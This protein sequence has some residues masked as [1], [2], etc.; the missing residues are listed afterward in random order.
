[1]TTTTI[2]TVQHLSLDLVAPHPDNV[3]TLLGDLDDLVRSLKSSGIIV[4]LLVLPA[5]PDGVHHIVAGHRRYAAAVKAGLETVAVIVRDLTAVEVLDAMLIENGQ[6]DDL[7]LGDSILAMARY[8]VLAPSESATKIGKRIGRTAA[9]CKTRLALAVLPA[10]VLARLNDGELTL[11]VAT[12]VAGLVGEG[13]DA[14]RACAEELSGRHQHDPVDAVAR[15]LRRQE[16][17]RKLDALIE[18]LDATGVTRLGSRQDARD[19]KAMPLGADGLGLD[20]DQERAHRHEPCHAV[21]LD[22]QGWSGKVEK[23]NFCTDPKRHRTT[24]KN[25][26]VSEIAVETFAA[27]SPHAVNEE[28]RA[29]KAARVARVEAATILLSGNRALPK[30]DALAFVAHAVCQTAAS[31]AVKKACLML[32]IPTPNEGSDTWRASLHAWLEDGGHP[33]K[34]LVALSGGDLETRSNQTDPLPTYGD[35]AQVSQRWL[36]FLTGRAGYESQGHDLDTA[37][38]GV[39]R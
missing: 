4:P 7:S 30:G 26:A 39:T 21:L 28:G 22:A 23:I 29:R 1:M 15:W 17:Q 27:A 18:K 25:E 36:E 32:S 2:E 37:T 38:S 13:D 31:V 6:R 35:W 10:D 5:D 3:R 20:K 9:W 19:I 12:A 14:M 11:P 24:A 33:V 16:L 8:Q 34:L